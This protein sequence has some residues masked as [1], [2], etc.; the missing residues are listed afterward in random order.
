M[1]TTRKTVP[2]HDSFIAP[3]PTQREVPLQTEQPGFRV[4]WYRW[5]ALPEPPQTATLH[6]R[7]AARQSRLASTTL[8]WMTVFTLLPLPV[9][10]VSRNA[11]LLA[12]LLVT[13]CVN[14]CS[15]LL[16]RKGFRVL[17][18]VLSVVVLDVGIALSLV[19]NPG[20]LDVSN[21]PTFDLLAESILVAVA[22]F[23]PWSV[24][25]VVGLNTLFIVGDLLLE[26]HTMGLGHLLATSSYDVVVR[27]VIL[28][29]FVAVVVYLWVQSA[30]HALARADR[31]EEIIA[32]AQDNAEQTRILREQAKLIVEERRQLETNQK[33]ILLMLV[34]GAKGDFSVPAP[35]L[36]KNDLWQITVGITT[37]LGRLKRIPQL[38]AY[39][40]LSTTTIQR[41]QAENA[42]LAQRLQRQER[43]HV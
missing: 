30:L 37:L 8:F 23:P 38:E 31:A 41:L 24:F 28:Q 36:R 5:T 29:L 21:L 15:V 26:R 10:L 39:L 1:N 40:A 27:P 6:Q 7:E 9:A 16:N 25:V 34:Q 32:L 33:Q 17:A 43:E 20:G 42:D 18:G 22:F 19:A 3:P 2:I 13:L 14:L 12:L 11:T 35:T 4:W